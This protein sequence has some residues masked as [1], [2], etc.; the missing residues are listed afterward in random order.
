M[1]ETASV[2]LA[3]A[4]CIPGEFESFAAPGR[5]VYLCIGDE[6]RLPTGFGMSGRVCLFYQEHDGDEGWMHLTLVPPPDGT[7]AWTPTSITARMPASFAGDHNYDMSDKTQSPVFYIV[8]R[9]GATDQHDH[10]DNPGNFQTNAITILDPMVNA[11]G[12]TNSGFPPS[13]G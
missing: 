5:E 4:H 10:G 11:D 12:R 7:A 2:L 1:S 9:P 13:H 6:S 8:V 3:D